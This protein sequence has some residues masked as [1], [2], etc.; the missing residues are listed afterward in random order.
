MVHRTLRKRRSKRSMKRSIKRYRRHANTRIRRNMYRKKNKKTQR[1]GVNFSDFLPGDLKFTTT[2]SILK[3]AKEETKETDEQRKAREAKVNAFQ[4]YYIGST[5]FPFIKRASSSNKVIGMLPNIP[6]PEE[7]DEEKDKYD[8]ELEAAEAA[9]AAQLKRDEE[10]EAAKAAHKLWS[11]QLIENE[12]KR[13]KDLLNYKK[14]LMG[15]N[16]ES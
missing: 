13:I 14:K 3:R 5:K 1:G 8:E 10:L 15:E 4:G 2:G 11:E 16:P 6:H 9:K 12:E 7:E